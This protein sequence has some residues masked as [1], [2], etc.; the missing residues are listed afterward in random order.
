[1][2]KQYEMIVIMFGGWLLTSP[3]TPLRPVTSAGNHSDCWPERGYIGE[4]GLR[5]LSAGYSPEEGKDENRLDMDAAR[6]E[7]GNR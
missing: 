4:K 7:G 2:G 6:A 1:M 5:P 3:L